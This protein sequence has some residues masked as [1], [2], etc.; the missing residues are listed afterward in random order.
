VRTDLAIIGYPDYTDGEIDMLQAGGLLA[1]IHKPDRLIHW[2]VAGAAGLGLIS[3]YATDPATQNREFLYDDRVYLIVPKFLVEMNITEWFKV[4]A[5]A[6]YRFVGMVNGVYTNQAQE[7]IPTFTKSDY[8][9]PE[10]SVSL[11]FGNF[12][13][14]INTLIK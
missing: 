3:L 13:T 6:G 1:Y 9:K 2:G 8:T 14:G 12:G 4:N 10:L 7:T 11:L 5:S